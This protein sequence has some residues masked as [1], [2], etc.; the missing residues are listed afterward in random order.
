MYVVAA[1]LSL[2]RFLS[3]ASSSQLA[4][5]S[6]SSAFF[7]TNFP[8][9]DDESEVYAFVFGLLRAACLRTR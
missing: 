5:A 3:V 4:V 6:S 8:S 9:L 2:S 7:V 1:A